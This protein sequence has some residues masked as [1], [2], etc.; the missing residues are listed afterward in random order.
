MEKIIKVALKSSLN[1]TEEQLDALMLVIENTPNSAVAAEM[2]LGI[3]EKPEIPMTTN[4][5]PLFE[6]CV[7][8]IATGY[9]PFTQKVN[10]SYSKLKQLDSGWIKKGAEH[11]SENILTRE[12][13]YEDVM[14]VLGCD[15]KTFISSYEKIII[16]GD[17]ETSSKG[18]IKKFNTEVPLTDWI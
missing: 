17:Y 6:G 16:Y 12:S 8:F 10:V 2:L 3:Y 14:E 11:I 15:S 13:W 5:Q 18:E 4:K 9:N 1:L 7:D